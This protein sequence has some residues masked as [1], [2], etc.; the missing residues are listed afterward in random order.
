VGRVDATGWWVRRCMLDLF[1][2][3]LMEGRELGRAE[4][5]CT[6]RKEEIKRGLSR[7]TV[8]NGIE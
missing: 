5:D 3:S 7:R 8:E 6:G 1:S 4:F 2:G